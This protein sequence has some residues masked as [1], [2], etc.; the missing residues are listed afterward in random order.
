MRSARR[1]DV[2]GSQCSI[3]APDI[4]S[5]DFDT[6][7]ANV[8]DG[9]NVDLHKSVS[10]AGHWSEEGRKEGENEGRIVFQISNGV[11]VLFS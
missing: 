3:P 2:L 7:D 8:F 5:I 9:V 1:D 11:T 4:V 6:R 10:G